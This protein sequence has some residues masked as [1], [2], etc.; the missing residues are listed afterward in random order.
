MSTWFG[1]LKDGVHHGDVYDPRVALVEV[2]PDEIR[3]WIATKGVISRTVESGIGAVT[4]KVAC[5][6][7]IRT[8]TQS[9][10]CSTRRI[11]HG[12]ALRLAPHADW[13]YPRLT[14]EMKFW[15]VNTRVSI[16]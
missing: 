14:L 13:T 12:A 2:I 1:D 7:E 9:E 5:P 6:G 3:Y 16:G 4:G 11:Q 8:I 10:V 15:I